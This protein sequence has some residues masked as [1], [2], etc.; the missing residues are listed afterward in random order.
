M[1]IFRRKGWQGN[2]FS[3]FE[4]DSKVDITDPELAVPALQK[5]VRIYKNE[6]LAYYQGQMRARSDVVNRLPIGA[7]VLA[8]IGVLFTAGAVVA[9]TLSLA[10][11][12]SV[13]WDLV[14]M[15]VAVIAYAFMSATLLYE[16]LTEGSGGYFRAAATVAAIRDL[17]TAYQFGEIGRSIAPREEGAAETNRW[18]TP[19][20]EFCESVDDIVAKEMT[21]WQAAYETAA[22]ARSDAA[23]DGLKGSIE[24]LQ[25]TA[26]AA[27]D[28]A[29]EAAKK[30]DDAANLVGASLAPATLNL[31]LG[32]ATT[33]G[34]A[35]IKIDGVQVATCANQRKFSI[36]K[37]SQG[38]H[39]IRIEFTPSTTGGATE[40]YEEAITLKSGINEVTI[41]VA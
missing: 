40:A 35:T 31:S 15:A 11:F 27:A 5:A 28:S 9:R 24:E 38:E 20:K 18:L 12:I 19:I 26:Q 13:G 39:H 4:F 33:A 21:D 22:K 6:R 34:T 16:R 37:L 1:G 25:K 30:A 8:V 29:K 41:S 14:M 2:T 23:T 10:Q 17:W 3:D 36:S 7:A 32:T